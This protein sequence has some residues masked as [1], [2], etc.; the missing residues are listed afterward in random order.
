MFSSGS[1]PRVRGIRGFV[2]SGA[3]RQ[4]F[5]PAGAGNTGEEEA[6]RLFPAVHPR[7]CGEYPWPLSPRIFAIGSSP[8]VRGIRPQAGHCREVFGSSPRVRGI[9]MQ[10]VLSIAI[11][12]VHP[13]GC[14]E[15]D[16]GN[17]SGTV[18]LGSS[19]RVRGIRP[20]A[21]AAGRYSSVHPRGCGEY[22]SRVPSWRRRAV[23]PRGCGEYGLD[24]LG[25]GFDG[26]SSPRV[27]GIRRLSRG[28][29]SSSRF[30][31]A[32]AGNT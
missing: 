12:A 2:A 24:Y 28:E 32:G 21:S 8:R 7:G 9:L 18:A 30:I 14:G 5:I 27:R 4:R 13:R 20:R 1:S 26:G 23:H 19:P 17:P 11:G 29:S 22:G 3:N 6:P 16:A 15:Y 31:P 25:V 10:D